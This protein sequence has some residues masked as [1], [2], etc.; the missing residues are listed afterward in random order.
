MA[1]Y[2]KASC[3]PKAVEE[4]LTGFLTDDSNKT[5]IKCY[6][7]EALSLTTTELASLDGEGRAIMSE[8]E[9]LGCKSVVI[10]NL[11]CPRAD[12][13]NDERWTYK[14]NFYSLVQARCDEL[15]SFGKL[16]FFI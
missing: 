16:V 14:Q 2:C 4:G 12:R 1:T 5:S 10:V 6:A 8:H 15:I 13:D 9:V 11:Y 3:T 7:N